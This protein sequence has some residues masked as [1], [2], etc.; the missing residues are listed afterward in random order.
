MLITR[1]SHKTAEDIMQ[2]LI[3]VKTILIEPS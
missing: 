1:V 3:D 2:K